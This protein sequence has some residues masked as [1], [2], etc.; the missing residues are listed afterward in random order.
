ML[1]QV[2]PIKSNEMPPFGK[3]A[4]SVDFLELIRL[5]IQA[6]IRTACICASSKTTKN[7]DLSGAGC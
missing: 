1:K 7:N 5:A 2:K 3:T 4:R 6:G